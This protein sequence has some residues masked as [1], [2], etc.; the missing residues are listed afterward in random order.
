[1]IQE[2]DIPEIAAK[3][4]EHYCDKLL[5]AATD[6]MKGVRHEVRLR[7]RTAFKAYLTTTTDRCSKVKTILFPDTPRFLYDFYVPIDLV[8]SST[9]TEIHNPTFSKVASV[10]NHVIISG[11]GGSGKSMTMRHLFLDASAS[12]QKIP[13]YIELREFNSF[14]G[15]LVTL[16][17]EKLNGVKHSIPDSYLKKGI[18][19]GYF[20]LLLDGFDEVMESR[21][22][23]V[24]KDILS[25][26]DLWPENVVIVS[27]RSDERLQTW[28]RFTSL[29]TAPLTKDKAVDLVTRVAFADDVKE[30]FVTD[31]KATLFARHVSFLS[32]PLLLTIMLLSYRDNADIPSKL[33]LFY[34]QAFDS[35]Y[36]RHDAL[37]PGGFKRK[38][39]VA[40]AQDDFQ[41]V[42]AAFCALTH[43]QRI[44]EFARSEA[45]GHLRDA[46]DI[47]GI[48][49]RPED[50]LADLL[51]SVCMLLQDGTK[52]RFTHRSFQE[53][54][55]AVF[56]RNA[57]RD[58]QGA[59]IQRL[60]KSLLMDNTLALLFEM[61]QHLMEELL[62]MPC[63]RELK[64]RV[65]YQ[66]RAS[67]ASFRRF[68][69]S[70]F[71]RFIIRDDDDVAFGLSTVGRQVW[72]RVQFIK[73]AYGYVPSGRGKH[74]LSMVAELVKQSAGSGEG[75]HRSISV[76]KV[77]RVR[78]AVEE[79]YI[80]E[81]WSGALLDFLMQLLVKI[82]QQ[83]DQRRSSLK[84][85]LLKRP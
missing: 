61:D 38:L 47:T 51:V 26:S 75:T 8:S 76:A 58:V 43:E 7:M 35:L 62:V 24:Q 79:L 46:G 60:S 67:K 64:E 37:K 17:L 34:S 9:H 54:F 10:S 30:R 18:S 36:N 5:S 57:S 41:R 59:M 19:L 45:Y 69:C 78:E 81:F 52:Y 11:T 33:H 77:M 15:D 44:T 27:S 20:T 85:M 82:E 55:T 2:T 23:S 48:A 80:G 73:E 1:M 25:F 40:L 74:S 66:R 49:V 13:I 84:S 83:H 21:A 4:I 28:E 63:L 32:N 71:D 39:H 72:G 31:L 42:L 53:Y 12:R 14:S 56:I 65:G 6:I 29:G 16:L 22:E 3:V 70:I 68:F 50:F